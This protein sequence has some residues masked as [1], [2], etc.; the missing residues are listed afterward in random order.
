MG[1][2]ALVATPTGW[3]RNGDLKLG[4]EVLTPFGT[5]TTVTGIYPK[6]VRPVYE[7]VLRDG[8]TAESCN[9]HLWQVERSKTAIRY[10]GTR[11]ASGKREFV[12]TGEN[13]QTHVMVSEIIDTD[14]LKAR[15]D[16]GRQINLPRIE[17]LAYR[18]QDLPLDPYVLGVILGDGRIMPNG[19]LSVTNSEPYIREELARRGCDMTHYADSTE[20]S[21]KGISHIIRDLGL[22]GKRSHEKFIPEMYLYASV[23]QRIDLLRG[24]M[25]TDGYVSKKN[26]IEFTSTSEQLARDTQALIR[27]L[28]G[29]V[30]LTHKTGV[31]YTSPTQVEPKSARDAYRLQNVR[32]QKLNPFSLPRKADRWVERDDNSGNRIVRVTYVRDEE[33]QCIS[34][35]DERHLYVTND[36]MPTHNTENIVF[37]KSTDDSMIDTLVKMSGTTHESRT[38]SKT[39]T[40]DNERVFNKNEGKISYTMTTK[41]RPVIQFNDFMFIKERNSIILKAGGSPIWNRNETAYP[42]SWRLLMNTIRIP[43]KE[44]SL[45]TIPTNSTAKDFDVRK[46]QPDFFAMLDQRIKQ[47]KLTEEYR[48]TYLDAY[49]LSETD[50]IR[51]DQNVVADDIMHAVNSKLFNLRHRTADELS[52]EEMAM[53][54]D[55]FG[56]PIDGSALAAAAEDNTEVLA[57]AASAQAEKAE[58]STKRYANGRISRDDLVA[59]GGQVNRQLDKV[60]AVAYDE[61]KAYFEGDNN[62]R[63]APT[64]ELTSPHG[65][66]YVRSS[67]GSNRPDIRMLEDAEDDTDTRVFGEEGSVGTF[68][69]VT[70]AFIKHLAEKSSWADIAGGRF[71]SE[72]ARAYDQLKR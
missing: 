49:G 14:E 46:N 68:Y 32:L 64:G 1:L 35:A 30:N 69:E 40:K 41:E 59:I 18:A 66:L 21:I 72:A 26:E 8:S 58:H 38:D 53:E 57:A 4:D 9:E 61:A 15:V 51:L 25:D 34:V 65:E 50:L 47:A 6:G 63:M 24:L 22:A 29:R 12:G 10:T 44:F 71:D 36:Y 60:L 5:V 43:G 2:D 39:I 42:M 7:V 11:D 27:S 55:E 45:Q 20:F 54:F 23:E 3:V 16:K 17:P 62:Y 48:Q 67:D 33:V 13:G 31:T 28:G 52:E 19:S 70:D 37:L 56:E